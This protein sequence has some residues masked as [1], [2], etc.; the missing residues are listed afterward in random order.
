[1][2]QKKNLLYWGNGGLKFFFTRNKWEF[3]SLEKGNFLATYYILS[4]LFCCCKD[5]KIP[6]WAVLRQLGG[7][8]PQVI[9]LGTYIVTTVC[10]LSDYCIFIPTQNDKVWNHWPMRIEIDTLRQVVG[11]LMKRR[12]EV[13]VCNSWHYKPSTYVLRISLWSIKLAYESIKL[14]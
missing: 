4:L 2:P 9:N 1:M 6:V 13:I 12:S 8:F 14:A 5:L 11:L 10:W 7:K 3:F